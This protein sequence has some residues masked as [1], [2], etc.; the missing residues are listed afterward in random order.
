MGRGGRRSG[1]KIDSPL[2]STVLASAA[3]GAWQRA[4]STGPVPLFREA[5]NWRSAPEISSKR[6]GTSAAPAMSAGS[7]VSSPQRSDARYSR[8]AGD[9]R[10]GR[11][12]PVINALA[13]RQRSFR[14]RRLARWSQAELDGLAAVNDEGFALVEA[15]DVVGMDDVADVL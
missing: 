11:D 13:G 5:K 2:L 3:T 7:R 15:A 1:G 10:S 14:R 12:D 8:F 4:T 9:R 6:C